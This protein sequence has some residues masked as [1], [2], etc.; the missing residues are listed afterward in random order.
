ML[1]GDQKEYYVETPS[2]L[3]GTSGHFEI[4]IILANSNSYAEIQEVSFE[5]IKKGGRI[6][7]EY[8]QITLYPNP[9]TNQFS[10]DLKDLEGIP[11]ML[12]V[13]DEQGNMIFQKTVDAT[14]C[15][16]VQVNFPKSGIYTVLIQTNQ[17][18]VTKKI[19]VSQ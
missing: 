10:I 7:A 5:E 13:N 16:N 15:D 12:I 4:R 11:Q 19:A 17:G 8:P 9:T 6:G 3:V 18:I 2:E 14:C 1:K